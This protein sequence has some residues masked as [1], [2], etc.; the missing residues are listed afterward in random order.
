[1]VTF[2][3]AQS[4]R[5]TTS[6]SG[7]ADMS[8]HSANRSQHEPHSLSLLRRED[9]A[10]I[11]EL[12]QDLE[13]WNKLAGLSLSIIVRSPLLLAFLISL[14]RIDCAKRAEVLH[15]RIRPGSIREAAAVSGRLG[16]SGSY[17][18]RISRSINI[19]AWY[20]KFGGLYK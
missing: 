16:T 15:R 6:S 20:R 12:Q 9:D 10:K 7:D 13:R 5:S 18:V 17:P 1:M 19:D 2:L 14:R 11:F 3:L 4:E 8:H